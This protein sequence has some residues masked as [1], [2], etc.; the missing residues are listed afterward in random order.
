MA[1]SLTS[2]GP[3]PWEYC[4]FCGAASPAFMRRDDEPMDGWRQ[5]DEYRWLCPEHAHLPAI[6][7]VPRD[8]LE[9]LVYR[10]ALALNYELELSGRSSEHTDQLLDDIGKLIE[11]TERTDR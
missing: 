7:F 2:M 3:P 11:H 1:R 9:N 4:R 6:M 5:I 10:L 8:D